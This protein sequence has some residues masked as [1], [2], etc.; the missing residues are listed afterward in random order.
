MNKKERANERIAIL[1]LAVVAMVILVLPSLLDSDNLTK[2]LSINEDVLTGAIAFNELAT[3][4]LDLVLNSNYLLG[5]IIFFL[6]GIMLTAIFIESRS[7]IFKPLS[8]Q[9]NPPP[10][11]NLT[12]RL[13]RAS[14]DDKADHVTHE[15]NCLP[16]TK[17]NRPKVISTLKQNSREPFKKKP[18]KRSIKENGEVSNLDRLGHQLSLVDQKLAQINPSTT[19]TKKKQSF[20]ER[21]FAPLDK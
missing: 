10:Q 6:V 19:S 13:R 3:P 21:L 8:S 7:H 20:L 16:V 9:D 15:I 1:G 5:F 18:I 17:V 4:S 2:L 12:S 14:L 11:K